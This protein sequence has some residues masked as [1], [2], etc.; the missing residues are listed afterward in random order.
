MLQNALFN[1]SY[2]RLELEVFPHARST[3]RLSNRSI[4]RSLDRSIARSLD[5]SIGRLVGR[6]HRR[7]SLVQPGTVYSHSGEARVSL[8]RSPEVRLGFVFQISK[9]QSTAIVSPKPLCIPQWR[10]PIPWWRTP[11]LT[12]LAAR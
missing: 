11:V 4:A 6:S 7:A 5:R 2:G 9:V 8:S 12:G 3:V 1:A 10:P